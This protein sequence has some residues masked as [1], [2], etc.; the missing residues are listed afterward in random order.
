VL[1]HGNYLSQKDIEICLGFDL[2]TLADNMGIASIRE[3]HD[4]LGVGYAAHDAEVR[5]SYGDK[6]RLTLRTGNA[7]GYGTSAEVMTAAGRMRTVV[8]ILNLSCPS[9]EIRGTAR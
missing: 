3:L 4:A 8:T 1:I 2:E 5:A 6:S 7:L 9:V